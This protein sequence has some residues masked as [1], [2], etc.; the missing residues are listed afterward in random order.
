MNTCLPMDAPDAVPRPAVQ[1]GVARST[2][3]EGNRRVN[4]EVTYEAVR[5]RPVVVD[6]L[7]LTGLGRTRPHLVLREFVCLRDAQTLD[8]VKD[9]LVEAHDAVKALGPY[10]VVEVIMGDSTKVLLNKLP[11]PPQNLRQ[12]CLRNPALPSVV[13]YSMPVPMLPPHC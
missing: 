8:E 5:D 2:P 13:F 10:E 7:R 9:V 1:P 12:R 11:Q 4:Y 6:M 3:V